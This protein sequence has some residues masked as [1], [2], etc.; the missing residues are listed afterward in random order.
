VLKK[1]IDL[2]NL[3][4]VDA[5]PEQTYANIKKRALEIIDAWEGAERMRGRDFY[6]LEKRFDELIGIL[7]RR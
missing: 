5:D 4:V 2:R 7:K 6:E 1:G 3:L